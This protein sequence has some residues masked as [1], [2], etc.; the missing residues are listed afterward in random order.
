MGDT[1]P[2]TDNECNSSLVFL[3]D[4]VLYLWQKAED[5]L[6]AEKFMKEGNIQLS[7]DNWAEKMQKVIMPLT[8]EYQVEFDKSL[9]REIK[10]GE[11][12]VKLQLQEKGDYL[13]F[14]PIFTYKGF[15]TKATDKETIT[16]PDGDKI[17]IIHR[18]K[19]AEENFLNKLESL[20]SM[21]V[22]PEDH[23]NSLV[24]KG[25][26]VLR[27]NWFFLFVDAMKEMKV[28]VYGFEALAKFPL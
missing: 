15:E 5:V 4:N 18:N 17:L 27:N 11:P 6:Q 26:D 13:V 22:R 1:I 28:P 24:L 21:F 23:K 25:A 14:Q 2:F 9:V 16:I 7:K 20:H 19:E 3:H 12:E 10:S 8:K